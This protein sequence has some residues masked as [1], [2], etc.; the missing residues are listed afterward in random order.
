MDWKK[1]SSRCGTAPS[2]VPGLPA[3]AE[4]VPKPQA[5]PREEHH[6]IGGLHQW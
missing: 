2:A 1:G 3:G 6:S 4:A 5:V